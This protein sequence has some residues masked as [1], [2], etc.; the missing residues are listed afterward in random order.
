MLSEHRVPN[1]TD[2]QIITGHKSTE[3]HTAMNDKSE[4]QRT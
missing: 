4:Q 1:D 2:H 3:A